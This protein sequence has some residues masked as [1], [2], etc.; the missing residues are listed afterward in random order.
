MIPAGLAAR[1]ARPEDADGI[2]ELIT[3]FDGTMGVEGG[4]SADDVRAFWTDVDLERGTRL[5]ETGDGHIVGYLELSERGAA[6]FFAGW[7]HP[8]SLG[9]GIGRALV[10]LGQELAARPAE[11]IRTGILA[12]DEAAAKLLRDEGFR[13]MRS[14]YR[15]AI[16]LESA[17]PEPE[18][19][20]GYVL[21][22]FEAADAEGFHAAVE[23]AFLDHWDYEP[24]SYEH[25]R[26]RTM[27]AADFDPGLWFVAVDGDEIAATLRGTGKRFGSGWINTLGVRRAWRR[28]G[29]AAALL[30]ASFGEFWRRGERRV[31]LAVDAESETGAIGL[32]EG[33]GMRIEWRADIYEKELT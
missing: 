6:P 26:K 13:A 10:R 15:M 20:S 12:V 27:D 21:R 31:Q 28:R 33:V 11:R 18:L 30:R 17:P 29:L 9:Q 14:F 8:D 3:A 24:E 19:P 32:Y 5:V 7:V 2:A 25:W 22:P 1:P 4:T 16:D 23:E